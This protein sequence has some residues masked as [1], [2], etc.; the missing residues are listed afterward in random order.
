[1]DDTRTKEE[2]ADWAHCVVN[3]MGILNSWQWPDVDGLEDFQGPRMHSA[4]WDHS[5]HFR[6]KVVSVTGTGSMTVQIVPELQK[7]CKQ[8]QVYMRSPTWIRLPSV[9]PHSRKTYSMARKPTLEPSIHVYRRGQEEVHGRSRGSG[10]SN[11]FRQT[12]TDEMARRMGPGHEE[13]KSFIVSKF[14]PGCRRIS[15]GDGYLEALVQRNVQP[16]FGEIKMAT[17]KG[18]VTANGVEHEMNIL[19]CAIGFNVAF[20]PPSR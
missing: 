20:K 1:M 18:L 14:A 12:I 8:V 4:S 3:G 5:V 16:I 2:W 13:L 17:K 11:S 15:P 6:R 10:L 7:I 9:L 19:V